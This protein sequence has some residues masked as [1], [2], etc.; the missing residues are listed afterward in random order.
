M[1]ALCQIGDQGKHPV[2][3]DKISLGVL[4]WV[5]L[6]TVG[7]VDYRLTG[8]C[9]LQMVLIGWGTEGGVDYWLL[10]NSWGTDVGQKGFWKVKRGVDECQIER[11]GLTV[12]KPQIPSI[13]PNS[14]CANGGELQKDCSCKCAG[15]WGGDS[16][17]TC[18]LKCENGGVVKNGCAKCACPIGFSGARCE[19]GFV[20][21]ALAT[22]E[23]KHDALSISYTFAGTAEPPTQKSFIG[24]Y[25]E[26]EKLAANS[27]LSEYVCGSGTYSKHSLGGKCQSSG[28]VQFRSTPT[29]PGKYFLAL[30]PYL[31]PNEFDQE[32]WPE[33][34]KEE[35][36]VGLFVVLPAGCTSAELQSAKEGADPAKIFELKAEVIVLPR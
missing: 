10:Q 23:G 7:G 24:M 1:I 11:F 31:P 20:T 26:G 3:T 34:V 18:S 9:S 8:N 19:G 4:V 36:I 27:L 17:D 12:V 21:S 14:V 25:K 29:E 35:D 5:Q 2:L 28:S 32:G 16:C 22:C 13:C 33:K 15:G 30:V 6:G